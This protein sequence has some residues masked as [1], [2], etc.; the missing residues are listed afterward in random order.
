MQSRWEGMS[1]ICPSVARKNRHVFFNGFAFWRYFFHFW[2][3]INQNNITMFLTMFKVV[4]MANFSLPI[5]AFFKLFICNHSLSWSNSKL[6]GLCFHIIEN[7]TTSAVFK[8][9]HNMAKYRFWCLSH[10][11]NW[12]CDFK[13][14]S[15]KE[16]RIKIVI[17]QK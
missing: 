5:F 9:W 6:T 11:I 4:A 3:N 12:K 17:R 16:I 13:L 14:I 2:S 8:L 10:D 7:H 15:I 1:C